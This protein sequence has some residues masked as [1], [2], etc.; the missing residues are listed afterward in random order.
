MPLINI[1]EVNENIHLAVW[2]I[3]EDLDSLEKKVRLSAGDKIIYKEIHHAGKALEFLAGRMLCFQAFHDLQKTYQPIYRNVFGKPEMPDSNYS[4][5]LSHTADYV[6]VIIGNGIDVGID[7]EKPHEKMRKVAPRI[8]TQEE[9]MFCNDQLL[10][11]SK[12]WSAKEVLYKLY[13]KREIDFR[14]HLFLKP[15]DENWS[16]MKGEIIKDGYRK[17]C[18]LKFINLQEYF[19]CFNTN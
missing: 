19:I 7:I 12:M 2:K 6:V 3:V 15:V 16:E 9:M 17:E 1:T 14:E 11:F 5:S 10:H 8:L 13:M 4:L 18:L